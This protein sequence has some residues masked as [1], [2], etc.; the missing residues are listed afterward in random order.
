MWCSSLSPAP[1]GHDPVDAGEAFASDFDDDEEGD[2]SP[3]DG[4]EDAED[5]EDDDEP[6]DPASVVVFSPA[7]ESVR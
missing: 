5:D 2:E 3:P 4:D 6:E 7:R 1:A